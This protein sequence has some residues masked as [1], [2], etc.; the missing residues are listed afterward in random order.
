MAVGSEGATAKM[1]SS[2]D[3]NANGYRM[4]LGLIF[5][6]SVYRAMLEAAPTPPIRT[7]HRAV[8]R[9]QRS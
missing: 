4:G 3:T 5:I 6:A 7:P 1:K 8:E 2:G 9:R